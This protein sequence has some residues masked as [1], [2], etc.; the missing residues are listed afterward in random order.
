[1]HDLNLTQSEELGQLKLFYQTINSILQ[2]KNNATQA[3]SQQ[4]S[5]LA[6]Q[7]HQLQIDYNELFS[8]FRISKEKLEQA[9]EALLQKEGKLSLMREALEEKEEEFGRGMRGKE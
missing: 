4:K 3:L 7:Y 1:M 9:E 8:N 6:Q 5:D 2:D